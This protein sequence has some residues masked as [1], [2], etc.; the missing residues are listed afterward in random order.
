MLFPWAASMLRSCTIII[1]TIKDII[2]IFT[3]IISVIIIFITIIIITLPSS[4]SMIK[5]HQTDGF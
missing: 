2:V 3:T 1:F 4:E 5:K